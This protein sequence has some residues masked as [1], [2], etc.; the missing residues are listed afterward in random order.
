MEYVRKEKPF[1]HAEEMHSDDPLMLIYTS[2]T[3]GKPKGTVHTHAGFP[4]KAAFDAG[5]GMN[6]KQGDRVLWVTDMGWMMGPFYYLALSL[7]EQRWLCMKVFRTSQ[8]QIVYGRQLINMK[9][10]ISVYHQH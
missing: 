9:L 2:G 8:K 10:H 6:I 4:L 1:V 7:M 5:F 3:T